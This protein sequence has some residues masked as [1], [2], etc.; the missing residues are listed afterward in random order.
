MVKWRLNW[1]MCDDLCSSIS[2]SFKM[3]NKKQT[4]KMRIRKI[5]KI[6]I[7]RMIPKCAQI[8]LG[9]VLDGSLKDTA[10]LKKKSEQ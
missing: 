6:K 3:D 9:N 4:T 10:L 2:F 1:T 5:K 7:K 8:D